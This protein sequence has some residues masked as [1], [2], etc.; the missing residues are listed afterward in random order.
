MRRTTPELVA[1]VLALPNPAS[2][3]EILVDR[4]FANMV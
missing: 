4:Q 1:T 3:A 2:I